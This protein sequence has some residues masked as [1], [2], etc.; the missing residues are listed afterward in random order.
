MSYKTILAH[1]ADETAPRR[2]V[3]LAAGLAGRFEGHLTA[4]AFGIE[5]NIAAYG[6]GAPGVAVI[7][8][9]LEAAQEQALALKQAAESW[10]AETGVRGDAITV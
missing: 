8:T 4:I 6:Y 2:N 10:I 5:P 3:G 1:W 7:G 9:E